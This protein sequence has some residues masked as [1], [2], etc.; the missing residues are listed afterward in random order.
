MQAHYHAFHRL[1]VAGAQHHAAH[2]QRVEA[3]A[4]R[5]GEAEAVEHVA[6]VVVFDGVGEVNHVGGV[7]LQVV[8][9]LDGDFLALGADDGLLLRGRRHYHAGGLVLDVDY[10]VK[11]QL[12]LLALEIDGARDGVAAQHHGRRV[13]ARAALGRAYVGTR[14]CHQRHERQHHSLQ[15]VNPLSH[16][17]KLQR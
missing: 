12:H 3:R 6:L 11:L 5:E 2:L 4:G 16:R 1:Q 13:V 10:L 8:L 17:F 14:H 7:R 15:Y 9:E